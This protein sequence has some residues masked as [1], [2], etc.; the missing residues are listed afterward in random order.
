MRAR[1]VPLGSFVVVGFIRVR[2]GVSLGLFECVAGVVGFIVGRRVLLGAPRG[3]LGSFRVNM[4][5][6][7]GR[8]VHLGCRGCRCVHSVSLGVFGWALGDVRGR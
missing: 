3:L 1:W 4:V 6:P 7:L 8:S 5:R 2:P